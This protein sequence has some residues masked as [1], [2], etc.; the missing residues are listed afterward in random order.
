MPG[1]MHPSEK[2][3]SAW[4][5]RPRPSGPERPSPARPRPRQGLLRE[6]DRTGPDRSRKRSALDPAA[7]AAGRAGRG[8]VAC[9]D[10]SVT[11]RPCPRRNNSG[12]LSL[13]AAR[14]L[15]FEVMARRKQPVPGPGRHSQPA[16][17][18]A[19]DLDRRDPAGP[20]QMGQTVGIRMTGIRQAWLRKSFAIS[21]PTATAGTGVRREFRGLH[22]RPCQAVPDCAAIAGRCERAERA[23]RLTAVP[24]AGASAVRA[25]I[26]VLD[27]ADRFRQPAASERSSAPPCDQ[28]GE[29]I[30]EG[31]ISKC[32]KAALRSLLA[33]TA[34]ARNCRV[35]RFLPSNSWALPAGCV[36]G[37]QTGQDCRADAGPL[38]DRSGCRMVRRRE[39]WLKKRRDAR[40]SRR[41]LRRSRR[42][43][44][45][46]GPAE[47]SCA[48]R[49]CPHIGGDPPQ[50]AVKRRAQARS[51]RDRC[52]RRPYGANP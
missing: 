13:Q 12:S 39:R 17:I 51:R 27:S 49:P 7:A 48:P 28:F 6:A 20:R 32:G 19:A 30:D 45:G 40:P 44:G 47:V 29:T 22:G 37:A 26:A 1:A 2:F 3:R 31:R 5:A 15:P 9:V 36:H 23:W 43:G 14:D 46:I 38:E 4:S 8:H 11:A 34:A 52:P 10:G 21:R 50:H 18:N 25:V 16:R 35:G 33:E 42:D 24:G 41:Q